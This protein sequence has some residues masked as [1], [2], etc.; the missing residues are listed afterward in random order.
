MNLKNFNMNK[1]AWILVSVL[2]LLLFLQREC[3]RC[4]DNQIEIK[5]DTVYVYRDKII[6]E[7]IVKTEFKDRLV[8]IDVPQIVDTAEILKDYFAIRTYTDTTKTPNDLTIYNNISISNN[9]LKSLSVSYDLI[10]KEKIVYINNTIEKEVY[11][12]KFKAFIGGEISYL[13]QGGLNLSPS[14]M[15][16]T[17]RDG[18]YGYRYG[19]FDKSHSISM[20][21][22]IRLRR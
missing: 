17:K 16:N 12:N 8:Y 4:P 19:L 14:L 1:I 13:P 3:S 10:Q 11:V 5:T 18:L 6:T 7:T 21:Y 15:I 2:L 22:K 20:Y 9:K